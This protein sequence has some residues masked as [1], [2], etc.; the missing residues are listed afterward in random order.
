MTETQ[1]TA[2]KWLNRTYIEAQEIGALQEKLEQMES[3]INRA[4]KPL[5]ASEIQTDHDHTAQEIK[6]AAY[7]DLKVEVLNRLQ[8]LWRQEA[9]SLEIIGKLEKSNHRTILILRYVNRM[10]WAKII[11]EMHIAEPTAF[12]FHIEALDAIAPLIPKEEA[13]E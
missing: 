3:E 10:T 12:R 5:G 4:V 1:Y 13:N 7:S 2:K 6:L 8:E 11:N 9:R